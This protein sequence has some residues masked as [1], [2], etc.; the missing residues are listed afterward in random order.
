MD[1][2]CS[3]PGVFNLLCDM[4]STRF[5]T[6]ELRTWIMRQ[7]HNVLRKFPVSLWASFV[8]VLD[9]TLFEATG[10]AL[11]RVW[12]CRQLSPLWRSWQLHVVLMLIWLL[13]LWYLLIFGFFSFFITLRGRRQTVKGASKPQRSHLMKGH[14]WERHFKA[15]KHGT[16][17]CVCETKMVKSDFCFKFQYQ[18]IL[19]YWALCMARQVLY[20][21]TLHLQSH[22]TS[23][24]NGIFGS[25][26]T[27]SGCVL[28]L[29]D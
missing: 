13:L 8:A 6:R 19:G 20:T 10:W 24:Q 9:C 29:F 22:D 7:F 21:I 25:V 23:R 26:S 15:W 3:L 18:N 28:P 1:L 2:T 16:V 12:L 11:L 14:W 5:D 4:S 27:Y 17:E